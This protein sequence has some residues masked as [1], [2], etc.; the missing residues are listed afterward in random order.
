M[1]GAN[2]RYL[3]YEPETEKYGGDIYRKWGDAV[4]H[5]ETEYSQI[6]TDKE[7]YVPTTLSQY[8]EY[9]DKYQDYS[10]VLGNQ[11]LLQKTNDNKYFVTSE[12]LI[13]N[14]EDYSSEKAADRFKIAMKYRGENNLLLAL[15]KSKIH[16]D[17]YQAFLK[18]QISD[19]HFGEE[20]L[21]Y[22]G[23]I[24]GKVKFFTDDEY[25]YCI[26]D[27][28]GLW[29]KT[30]RRINS[31]ES[32][33]LR[34]CALSR[35][36]KDTT[37]DQRFTLY[38]DAIMNVFISKSISNMDNMDLIYDPEYD[39]RMKSKCKPWIQIENLV[40]NYIRCV[41]GYIRSIPMIGKYIE[42]LK[43]KILNGVSPSKCSKETQIIWTITNETEINRMSDISVMS[44]Y[45]S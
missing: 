20:Y 38:R 5:V 29:N 22:M 10:I 39:K 32:S 42:H 28:S 12:R 3:E 43:I 25:D 26:R 31:S 16:I 34:Y 45:L 13:H 30:H 37:Y 27:V 23:Y 7:Y 11:L 15:Y 4:Q 18:T 35:D 33:A 21:A 40:L 36:K 19:L 41:Y 1:F 24:Y 9:L 8:I 14:N 17:I 6:V 44:F 2:I